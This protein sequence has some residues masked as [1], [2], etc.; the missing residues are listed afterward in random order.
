MVA[1]TESLSG[2]VL[3]VLGAC[4]GESSEAVASAMLA[5]MAGISTSA[6]SARDKRCWCF[7]FGGGQAI[8]EESVGLVTNYDDTLIQLSNFLL[9]MNLKLHVQQF[10][11]WKQP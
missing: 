10:L 8:S 9:G 5:C 11:I 6:G 7:P 3:F 1:L 2:I 4:M